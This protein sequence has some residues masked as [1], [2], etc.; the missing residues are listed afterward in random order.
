MFYSLG[1]AAIVF[2]GR[3]GVQPLS[4]F[5]GSQMHWQF[6]ASNQRGCK[7]I[8]MYRTLCYNY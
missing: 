6:V 2:D 4:E 3:G 8:G 7:V 5:G 1:G